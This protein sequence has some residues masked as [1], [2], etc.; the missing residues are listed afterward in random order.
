MMVA[1]QKHRLS[2]GVHQ[3]KTS[4]AFGTLFE[5]LAAETKY[6]LFRQYG[7]RNCGLQFP[8]IILLTFF[9]SVEHQIK[10]LY[11]PLQ[12]YHC[13]IKCYFWFHNRY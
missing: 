11:F 8:T 12:R 13:F 2:C 3:M 9:L 5:T 4:W 10:K 6:Y 1:P 7:L